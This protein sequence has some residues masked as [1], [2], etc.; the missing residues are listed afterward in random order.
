MV[1]LAWESSVRKKGEDNAHDSKASS[2]T[3]WV[4]QRPAVTGAAGAAGIQPAVQGT[5]NF[6][7]KFTHSPIQ[8]VLLNCIARKREREG[9]GGRE[10]GKR[11]IH[12]QIHTQ[13][14]GEVSARYL[15]NPA[16]C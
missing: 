1:L 16:L 7:G 11:D 4:L 2:S 5:T 15:A 6:T 9:E 3:A 8:I 14:G 12:T 13:R 10:G